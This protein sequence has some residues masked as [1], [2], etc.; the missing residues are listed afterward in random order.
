MA[1]AC[2]VSEMDK[3][4]GIYL[5]VLKSRVRLVIFCR[6]RFERMCYSHK[7]L[8][9]EISYRYITRSKVN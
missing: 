7:N 1:M 3:S 5:P 8:Q 2:A 6:A 9:N 4:Y